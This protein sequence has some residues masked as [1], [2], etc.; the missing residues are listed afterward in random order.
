MDTDQQCFE[1]SSKIAVNYFARFLP[2]RLVSNSDYFAMKLK[3]V[4]NWKAWNRSR[5]VLATH[6][7]G[8]SEEVM[9]KDRG[10]VE[11]DEVWDMGCVFD[12]WLSS[13]LGG[14]R[15]FQTRHMWLVFSAFVI[16]VSQCT[17]LGRSVFLL[18]KNSSQEF[19]KSSATTTYR[20]HHHV[21]I[22]SPFLN[23]FHFVD[24]FAQ[25]TYPR[26]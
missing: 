14:S 22:H 2:A 9:P 11:Y 21:N 1:I 16:R 5:W 25:S 4:Q 20:Q 10:Y 18:D 26:N 12:I 24:I 23:V 6:W 17:S 3:R 13:D 19:K 8:F 7:T 15:M